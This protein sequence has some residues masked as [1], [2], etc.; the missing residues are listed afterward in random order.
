[1]IPTQTA[2]AYLLLMALA[3]GW[4]SSVSA[5]YP[6]RVRLSTTASISDPALNGGFYGRDV[7]ASRNATL[8]ARGE[9]QESTSRELFLLS[10]EDFCVY[11]P[12]EGPSKVSETN[13]NVVS[14]CSKEEHNTRLIPD[15]TLHGV[16]Y[17]KAPNWVQVSGYGDFT[18]INI[19]QG[20]SGGQFDSSD[21]MP[22]GATLTLSK[23]GDPAKNWVTLISADTFCVRA[24]TGDPKFCPTQF[25]EMGCF[26]LTSDGVGWDNVWQD[27]EGDDGEP[28]GV[29]DGKESKK[30]DPLPSMVI[31]P[32]SNC[33]PGSSLSN[34]QTPAA[35]AAKSGGG[36]KGGDKGESESGSEGGSTSWA[37]V[38]TC[39]P[40]TDT[41]GAGGAESTSTS[42]ASSAPASFASEAADEKKEE[43]G[44]A[45]AS[46]SASGG[47]ES[48]GTEQ[49]GVTQLATSAASPS[50]TSGSGEGG[51]EGGGDGETAAAQAPPGVGKR[52][53]GKQEGLEATGGDDKGGED[54]EGD[55]K[56]HE[57]KAGGDGSDNKGGDGG[58]VTS[59]GQCCFTTWTPT[60]IG[61]AGGA[62]ETGGAGAG[63]G[64]SSGGAAAGSG[65]IKTTASGTGTGTGAQSGASGSGSGS[66]GATKTPSPL[67]TGAG[68]SASGSGKVNAS[69]G[70]N[71]SGN[72]TENGAFGRLDIMGVGDESGL[73]KLA[74]IVALTV[75]SMVGGGMIFV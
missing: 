12:A 28:P 32:V 30:G 71:G 10:H 1:M 55:V 31:P 25:D 11:G 75:V 58:T 39:V 44:H 61:G 43:T 48:G 17:V 5:Q 57:D 19:A 51:G 49:V 72:G 68:A 9:N 62:K 66:G 34:G 21:H 63:A 52:Q 29:F 24:C 14:Y 73:G 15:G 35:G 4:T 70:A 56:D 36:D 45:S 64:K 60:I 40:C 8:G 3:Q 7:R 65:S 67:S 16:T 47:G 26:F 27:C 46:S 53:Q 23:G 18:N 74:W 41:V 59:N 6:P 2:T 37:P 38:Q 13:L 42:P 54:K 50:S 69:G 20:D 22:E 33:Q